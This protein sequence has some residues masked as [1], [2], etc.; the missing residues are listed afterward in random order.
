MQEIIQ[1]HSHLVS[2]QDRSYKRSKIGNRCMMNLM[3]SKRSFLSFCSDGL[4]KHRKD[5]M[6]IG[7]FCMR[8]CRVK[9]CTGQKSYHSEVQLTILCL[10]LTRRRKRL[11]SR[12][13]LIRH[14]Y[15]ANWKVSRTE[16]GSKS[17]CK[18][19][20]EASSQKKKLLKCPNQ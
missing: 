20:E 13:L 2:S 16:K 1:E 17:S 8:D 15:R 4:S 10:R 6:P 18:R 7:R 11:N 19:N 9:E 3:S 5:Q 14:S 12:Q